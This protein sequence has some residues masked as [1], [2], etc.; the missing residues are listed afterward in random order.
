VSGAAL[1][2][3]SNFITAA[4]RTHPSLIAS[5]C[6]GNVIARRIGSEFVFTDETLT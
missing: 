4:E 2:T 5:C 1:G 6:A 3:R